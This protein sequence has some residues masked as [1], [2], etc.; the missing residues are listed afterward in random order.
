MDTRGYQLG[1]GPENRW[2]TNMPP[3]DEGVCP[4][5]VGRGRFSALA[6]KYLGWSGTGGRD[7]PQGILQRPEAGDLGQKEKN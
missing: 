2:V 1:H 6:L 3:T 4:W 7:P 5:A